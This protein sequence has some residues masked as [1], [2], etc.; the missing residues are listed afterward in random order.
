[1]RADVRTH[2]DGHHARLQEL[3]EQLDLPFGELAVQVQRAANV[4][5]VDVV[6]QQA[7]PALL[8]TIEW[9]EVVH[10][11]D[12][13]AEPDGVTSRH[14]VSIIVPTSE[15]LPGAWG[16]SA[17]EAFPIHSTPGPAPGR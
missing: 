7:M 9:L 15:H 8:Q 4:Q 2:L 11:P 1:M 12:S 10:A 6:Q 3:A 14:G 16:H 17:E 5:V 13:R